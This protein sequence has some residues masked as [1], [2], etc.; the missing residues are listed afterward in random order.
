MIPTYAG[1][2]ALS[3]VIVLTSIL[4]SVYVGRRE[5]TK[6][7]R[8]YIREGT[9]LNGIGQALKVFVVNTGQVFGV[10]FVSGIGYS[11]YLTS[12]NTRYYE[13][14]ER[15]GLPYLFIMQ[16][17]SA[18]AWIVMF[19]TLLLLTLSFPELS[20]RSVL[21]AGILLAVPMSFLIRKIK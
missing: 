1:V 18:I 2:G 14:I 21:L 17:A 5:E 13:K 11:L 3:S 6:G 19:G 10:N 8:H 20:A 7:V 15:Y 9:L 4:V 16:A 12:Y